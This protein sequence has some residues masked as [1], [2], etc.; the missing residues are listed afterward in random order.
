[1]DDSSGGGGGSVTALW[2]RGTTQNTVFLV[3]EG[4]GREGYACVMLPHTL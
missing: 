1:M 4:E 3:E 2:P